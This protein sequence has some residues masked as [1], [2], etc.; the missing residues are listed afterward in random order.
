MSYLSLSPSRPFKRYQCI[1]S[2]L[3]NKGSYSLTKTCVTFSVD[4]YDVS[5][6]FPSI[7]CWL[8][9]WWVWSIQRAVKKIFLCEE[10]LSTYCKRAAAQRQRFSA[11]D[12]E[13]KG[14]FWRDFIFFQITHFPDGLIVMIHPEV[15]IWPCTQKKQNAFSFVLLFWKQ[16]EFYYTVQVNT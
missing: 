13:C 4:P 3:W 2:N 14:T 15:I 11:S 1:T 10:Q 16:I 6:S 9:T 12:E 7:Q 5:Q 8:I